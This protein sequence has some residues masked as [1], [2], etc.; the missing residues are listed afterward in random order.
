MAEVT[1]PLADRVRKALGWRFLAKFCAFGLRLAVL[2]VLARLVSVADFGLIAQAVIVAGLAALFSEV[3]MGPALVQRRDLTATHIRVAYTVSLLSGL[4]L[5]AAV[6]ALAPLAAGAFHTP[7]VVP[8]LRLLSW[9]CL[10]TSLGATAGALLR[11]ELAYRR[12]F[13]AEFL[14]YSIGYGVVGITLALSGYGAWALAWS[15]VVEALLRAGLYYQAAPHP[16]RPSLARAEAGQ[17]LHFGGG[18]LLARLAN[19]TAEVGDNFVVGHRLGAAALGLYSRAYQLMTLPMTEFSQ[20]VSEVLFPAYA[21]IQDDRERLRRAAL[22]AISVSA[23]VVF[24][25]LALL[26]LA[27]PELVVGILGA[28]W[29]GAVLPLQI[30]CLG[31]A[32]RTVS[33]LADSVARAKGAVYTQSGCHGVY[34]LCVIA[35]S[36]VGAQWGIVGVAG[37]VVVALA[38]TYVLTARLALRLI[39]SRWREFC[40]AQLPGVLLA[41]AIGGLTLPVVHMLR[42]ADLPI[43]L[44]LLGTVL[45]SALSALLVFLLLERYWY[46]PAD[47]AILHTVKQR[48]A[49]ALRLL[50]W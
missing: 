46:D 26:A 28:Q 13:V 22:A 17:L 34:A 31:G 12:L 38:V 14:S 32:F 27:A 15:V 50:S 5:T 10:C 45:A 29:A 8:I 19:Y 30:L 9:T 47:R 16:V 36:A 42:T 43:A 49:A 2:V 35:A 44:V 1:A 33:N 37:G 23:L 18:L 41:A 3:G 39:G 7:E 11:R 40:Q 4:A 6:W 20:V 24:P 25:M 48:C 21:E